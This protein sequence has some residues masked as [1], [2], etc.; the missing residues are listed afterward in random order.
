ME[1]GSN[2]KATLRERKY[3]RVFA[4]TGNNALAIKEAGYSTSSSKT[5]SDKGSQLRQRPHIQR[6][7]D[8][9]ME[10]FWPEADKDL[11][12][13]IQK[14]LTDPET[15]TSDFVKLADLLVRIKGHAAPTKHQ[16]L[17]A[18]IKTPLGSL[19][20]GDDGE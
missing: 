15:K 10:S 17:V 13:G 4:K 19:G 18:T 9:A 20:G 5:I 6:E 14:R 2:K 1:D 16:R 11:V 7:I 8:K 12:D 3:A